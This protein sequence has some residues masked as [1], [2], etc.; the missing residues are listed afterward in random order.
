[1]QIA[2]PDQLC[3]QNASENGVGVG[4]GQGSCLTLGLWQWEPAQRENGSIWAWTLFGGGEG[5]KEGEPLS[6]L[7]TV[8]VLSLQSYAIAYT[9]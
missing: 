8:H 6:L 1:M 3:G 5:R 4:E 7:P 9:H 2:F